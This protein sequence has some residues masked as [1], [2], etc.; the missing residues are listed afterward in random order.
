M[1]TELASR[2]KTP[3]QLHPP[4]GK[5][6]CGADAASVGGPLVMQ[7]VMFKKIMKKNSTILAVGLLIFIF[8]CALKVEDVSPEYNSL[9]GN[10]FSLES[11]MYISGV[12]LPPGYG[13]DINIYIIGPTQPSWTGPE[14]ITR[15][16]LGKGTILKVQGV[17]RSV[18]SAL[19]EGQQIDAVVEVELYEKA[20]NVPVVIELRYLRSLKWLGKVE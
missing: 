8:G 18:N 14:L 9:L 11:E 6:C 10:R 13:K 19:F 5:Q 17:R 2:Q 16:T 4:D 12:N 7:V 1:N 15:N 20:V 3:Q